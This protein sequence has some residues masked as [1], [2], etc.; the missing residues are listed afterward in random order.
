M[1]VRFQLPQLDKTEVIRPDE[2]P[3]LKT[4]GGIAVVGSSPTASAEIHMCVP[5]V[6]GSMTGSNLV[7]Q[8]SSPW[9]RALKVD[10]GGEPSAQYRAHRPTGG[11][12]RRMPE[13]SVQVRVGPLQCTNSPVAQWR[14]Q[15]PYKETIGGSSPPRTT[16]EKAEG[17]RRKGEGGRNGGASPQPSTGSVGNWQT[18]LI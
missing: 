8:G 5:G 2:E 18:T 14:R 15:L 4:G 11:R 12:R 3:V 7:G 16:S 6:I 10:G 13:I 9:G 17:G 1:L